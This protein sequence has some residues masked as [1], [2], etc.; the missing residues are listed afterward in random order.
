MNYKIKMFM[1]KYEDIHG[2]VCKRSA[3]GEFA[4][5]VM[6]EVAHDPNVAHVLDIHEVT[7]DAQIA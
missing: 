3:Y 1:V 6:L 7:K 2:A 5:V 4:S